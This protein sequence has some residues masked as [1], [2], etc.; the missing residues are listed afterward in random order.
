MTEQRNSGQTQQLW[1]E[2]Q[3]KPRLLAELEKKVGAGVESSTTHLC[4]PFPAQR[5]PLKAGA[6]KKQSLRFTLMQGNQAC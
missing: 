2:G 6:Q 3:F 4:G 5:P 1:H